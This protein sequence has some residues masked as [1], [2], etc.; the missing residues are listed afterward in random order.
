MPNGSRL[1]VANYGSSTVTPITVA[2]DLAG[3]AIRVGHAPDALAITPNGTTA[4][5]VDADSDAVTPITTATG[6]AGHPIR[7]GHTP[8]SVAI[9]RSGRTAYVVNTIGQTVTPI[10]TATR[11]A[12]RPILLNGYSYPTVIVMAPTGHLAL[13]LGTYSGHVGL[14]DTKARRIVARRKVGSSPVAVAF[15]R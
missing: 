4:F 3:L 2:T 1:Y 9:S 13:T 8:A 12:G 5:V 11:R 14:V 10:R 7:V 6:H 15:G